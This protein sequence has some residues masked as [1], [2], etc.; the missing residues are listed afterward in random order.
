MLRVRP[1]SHVKIFQRFAKT[2]GQGFARVR[3][4]RTRPINAFYNHEELTGRNQ[5]DM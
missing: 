1:I 4:G 5:F 2:G 3:E